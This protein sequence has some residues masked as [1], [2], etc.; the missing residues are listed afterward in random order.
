VKWVVRIT[1]QAQA[2]NGFFMNPGYRYPKYSL[3][4][5]RRPVP[6]ARG[7]RGHAGEV[8]HH[9]TRR[10]EQGHAGPV[11]IRGF[12]WAG[13][14]AIERV[15][16]STD[17][18]AAGTTPNSRRKSCLCLAD[19]Q[20]AMESERSGLLHHPFAR[21]R[22]GRP[23]QPIVAPGIRR[24]ICG[25][26]STAWNH[27]GEKRMKSLLPILLGAVA[28]VALAAP[29]RPLSKRARKKRASPARL[30]QSA[31]GTLAA[32]LQGRLE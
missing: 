22:Y 21:H 1:A 29:T 17:A 25:T 7:D 28:L 19:V 24:A 4:L 20:P 12:A 27:R 5:A 13:E 14:N 9:R 18:A 26:P 11:E 3:P 10:S 8:D 23:V 31:A 15:E 16:V 6:R 30:P 2:G 32:A